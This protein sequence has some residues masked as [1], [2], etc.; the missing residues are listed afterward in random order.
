[1]EIRIGARN[2]YDFITGTT[3]KPP[4]GDKALE[5]WL[6]ENNRVKSLLIDYMSSALMQR[7]IRF[8]TAKK[9]WDTV[10]KTFYDGSDETQLFELNQKSFTTQ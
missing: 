3:S 7:F 1:M 8:Q 5:T 6:V 10:S 4:A 2:K 9:I